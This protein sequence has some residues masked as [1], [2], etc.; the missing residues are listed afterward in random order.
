MDFRAKVSWVGCDVGFD[1]MKGT[2]SSGVTIESL[3]TLEMFGAEGC[4]GGHP[5]IVVMF[6]VVF[7]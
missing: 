4:V 6:L 3:G 5:G 7:S 1:G 2:S